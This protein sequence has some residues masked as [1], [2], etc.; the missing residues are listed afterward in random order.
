MAGMVINKYLAI[1]FYIGIF[2]WGFL[3][4]TMLFFV[5]GPL[6]PLSGIGRAH[7]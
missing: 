1:P 7:V 6:G 2:L 5:G 3:V 4:S